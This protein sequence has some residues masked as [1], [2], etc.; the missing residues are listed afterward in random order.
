M[1]TLSESAFLNLIQALE[2]S[3]NPQVQG[4]AEVLRKAR[5]DSSVVVLI[6]AVNQSLTLSMME[7]VDI[8]TF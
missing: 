7:N 8:T 6:E 1:H 3:P 5:T 2:I 4:V